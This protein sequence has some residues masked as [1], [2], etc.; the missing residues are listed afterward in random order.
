MTRSAEAKTVEVN[1]TKLYYELQGAGPPLLFIPGVEGDAE[2][3]ARVIDLLDG[4]F[5]GLSYDRRAHSRSPAPDGYIGTTVDRQTDDAAALL[6][7][8]DLAPATVWGGDSGAVIG[9]NLVLRYPDLVNGAML[10][11]PPLLAGMSEPHR[12]F[13]L[14]KSKAMEGKAGF[15]RMLIGDHTYDSLSE[16]YRTRLESDEIWFEH[17][18][19]NF[20]HYKPMYQD[21]SEI[22]KPVVVLCGAES[23]PFFKEAADWLASHVGTE[24]VTIPGGHGVHYELPGE[25]ARVIR[26]SIA[27]GRFQPPDAVHVS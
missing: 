22:R 19:D 12:V 10:H 15:L 6:M 27:S 16:E 9:V 24:T 23:P 20:E 17:E 11:E 13:D 14:L 4:Q 3:Y 2:Q 18:F 1:D 21:F 5:T 7:A 8:L 25:V 26:D